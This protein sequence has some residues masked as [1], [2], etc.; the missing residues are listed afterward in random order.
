MNALRIVGYIA[1]FVFALIVSVYWTFPFD[2]AKDRI[3]RVASE[4]TKM[5]IT[6]KSLEPSWVTGAVAKGVKIRRP[7]VEAPIELPK[8][9]ARAHILPML[10]GGQGFTVDLPIAK[11]DVH[12]D[13]VEASK[14]MNVV[15]HADSVEL[16]LVPGLADAIGI[17]LSGTADIDVDMFVGSDPKTSEG[18]IKL[19]ATGVEI[20]KGGKIKAFPVPELPVGS[21]DWTIPVKKGKAIFDKLTLDGETIQLRV[22]GQITLGNPVNRSIL[23][24]KVAFKPTPEFLRKEPLLGALLKNIRRAK[25]SDGFYGYAISGN[26]KRPRVFP[27][28]Q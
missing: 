3:L 8:V 2:A 21:F 17:P 12:A 23:N 11:G 28:R 14:G 20:L 27:K 1:F 24:L 6:A 15:A 7:G 16:A 18:V 25:G 22:D 5:E 9:T 4:Q 13:V 19:K 26:L 10:T